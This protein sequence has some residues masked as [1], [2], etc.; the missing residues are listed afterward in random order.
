VLAILA[1]AF[2]ALVAGVMIAK[3]PFISTAADAVGATEAALKQAID[4]R[5]LT[6][7]VG[8]GAWLAIIGSLL[9]IVAGVQISSA[10]ESVRKQ[11]RQAS[12]SQPPRPRRRPDGSFTS[13]RPIRA[14][15]GQ[16]A[17]LSFATI[18]YVNETARD[19]VGTSASEARRADTFSTHPCHGT[20]CSADT[21]TP[22]KAC[23]HGVRDEQIAR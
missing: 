17:A 11:S 23:T 21:S 14:R 6:A 20:G 18:S 15:S 3:D 13:S 16:R 12:P 9:V 10:R 7:T 5:R 2:G 1:G 8:L 19:A 22:T 4:A